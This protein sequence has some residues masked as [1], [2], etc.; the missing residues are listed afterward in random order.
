M[1]NSICDE[2]DSKDVEVQHDDV[3]GPHLVSHSLSENQCV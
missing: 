3:V 1:M 2:P